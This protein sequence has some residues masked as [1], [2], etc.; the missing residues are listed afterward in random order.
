MIIGH[1]ALSSRR[2]GAQSR[3]PRLPLPDRTTSA[4]GVDACLALMEE[5]LALTTPGPGARRRA[6]A[7]RADAARVPRG[8]G[9]GTPRARGAASPPRASRVGSPSPAATT[10]P[11][12]R[13][14]REPI[15]LTT[16]E[17]ALYDK[18]WPS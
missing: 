16:T 15:P 17:R 11:P 12:R 5:A 10:T 6:A 18:V 2:L 9:A 14:A 1:V 4:A 8:A 13:R 7:A 3:P